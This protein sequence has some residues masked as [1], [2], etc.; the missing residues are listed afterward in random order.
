MVLQGGIALH[1]RNPT[2]SGSQRKKNFYLF[3]MPI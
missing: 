1:V 2:T 3:L